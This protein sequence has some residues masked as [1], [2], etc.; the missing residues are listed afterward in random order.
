MSRKRE[1]PASGIAAALRDLDVR[2][3]TCGYNLRGCTS[4]QCPECGVELKLAIDSA[5]SRRG[6]WLASLFGTGLST[7]LWVTLLLKVITPVATA[8]Q[9]PQWQAMVAAGLQNVAGLPRWRSIL[10]TIMCC[11][12]SGGYLFV[13]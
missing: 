2:C 10:F 4:D 11:L 8:L 5:D 13:G 3:H 6:W 7:L 9:N 12:I 1:P